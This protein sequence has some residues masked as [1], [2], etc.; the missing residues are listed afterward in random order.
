MSNLLEGLR[1][2]DLS[3]WL[4]GPAAGQMLADLG[5]SVVKVEPPAGDPMRRLG[6]QDP[7]GV[8]A[9]YKLVN[10]GKTVL[11]LDLKSEEGKDRFAELLAA[12][13]VLLESYR[14]G[15]L[16]KLGFGAERRQALRPDLIHCALSGF[17]QTGPLAKRG[18]HDIN[19]LALGG[20]LIA[21]GTAERPVAA[22]PPVADHASALQAVSAI[23]AALFRRT[24]SGQ[25]ASL[26]ISLT[27]TV[28][29]W[30]AIPM[31]S[32][33]RG[34][35]PQR[36]GDVLN[37][38]AAF[39]RIYRCA[40]GGFVSLGAIEPKFWANFCSAV[41]RESWIVRQGEAPPQNGL[42]EEVS[43]LFA[44][45][46]RSHWETLLNEV[47]CCFQALLTPEEVLAHPQVQA[48]GQVNVSGAEGG[49]PL[50]EIGFGG[51]V[52][53]Q[54][55]ARRTPLQEAAPAEVLAQWWRVELQ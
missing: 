34:E 40:D 50:V 42:I 33:L 48:R 7:D 25:G 32:A 37:G 27:E 28:L 1:V 15:T 5:A 38:G 12:A 24:R 4:P 6:P 45:R 26:D 43:T 10:A 46:P 54:P 19:Y 13:D 18:G 31:T 20:G 14:P 49:A 39:Y 35:A 55:P 41:G 47:D 51:W 29:A 53:G 3:Q 17:G 11:R 36:E 52:N 16:N 30:Q 8:S 21:S 2:I 9:W 44:S 22:F 23:L